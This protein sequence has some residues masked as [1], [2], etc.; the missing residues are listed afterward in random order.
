MVYKDLTPGI[1]P[2]NDL[3]GEWGLSKGAYFILFHAAAGYSCINAMA[4]IFE[5][6]TLWDKS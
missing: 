3:D 2:E 5:V 4:G 6:V 1:C